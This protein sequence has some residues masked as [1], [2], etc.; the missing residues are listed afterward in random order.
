MSRS[1]ILSNGELAVALDDRAQVRDIYYPYVGLEDHVRGHY[2]HRIGVWSEGHLSWLSDP[3]WKVTVGCESEAL[4]SAVF[5]RNE[6]MKIELHSTDIV[7][8]ERSI[9]LRKIQIKNVS[10]K[11][12]DIKLYIGHQFEIYK[13]HGGDTAYFDPQTHS[14]IHYKGHR[15]FLMGGL[16]NEKPF[17]DYVT[18]LAN[19]AGHEGSHKDA[20][21]GALT[22]NPI[23]HGPADSVVGFYEE[24]APGQEHT[25]DYWIAAGQT[26]SEAQELDT[27]VRTKK[28]PAHLI[29]STR[30]Y[31]KA[32]VNAYNWNFLGLTPEHVDLFKR[33]LLYIRGHVDNGGGILASL[34]SD[35]LNYGLDTYAYVWPRDAS[36]SVLALDAVGDGNSARKFFEFCK[37]VLFKDGYLM[38]KY[39][40]DLSLGSSWHPW[41][42]NGRAELPIQEDETAI[43]VY[44]LGAHYAH[45]HDV[46]FLESM[47][48]QFIEKTAD[49]MVS[50][51]DPE[52]HLPLASYD[53]WEEKRGVST[54]SAS[55]VFG[56]L[57]VAAE[58]SRILGK[59]ENEKRYAEAAD[60]MKEGILKY[61]WDEKEGMFIKHLNKE[62]TQME[63]DKTL[64]A[65]SVY[66]IFL[67][68][69]LPHDDPR[70]KRAFEITARRLSF[71]IPAGGLAR[72]EGDNYFRNDRESAGNPWIVTTLWYAEY[73]IANAKKEQDFN[74]V[75]DIFT[76][77]T[78]HMLPSGVLPEQLNPQTGEQ[79]SVAPLTWSHSAYVTAVIKYLNKLEELGLCVAC[80]PAP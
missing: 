66:G 33:S 12:R 18:G 17:Q 46:T 54:Y 20:E 78:K 51:R 44:A 45:T 5:A 61:L 29:R 73:L 34:D 59:T 37:Q 11:K 22:K 53:L 31:W 3:D 57:Q 38:H 27:F 4:A 52:T 16:I 62:G 56:A 74:H 30:D 60:A 7:Y 71:G 35:T 6:N 28:S 32:W 79:L 24:Y 77:V 75:R 19:F 80:N 8:N 72:Y 43:V 10:D 50:Y 68:E 49:F 15:V 2:V 41:V 67:F 40:P 14:V 48:D 69:V 23:E 9:F 58:L 26:I 76:W 13:S 39:L 55:C 36:Y 64:D 63:F 25:I 65:S 47:Y 42:R 21:D 70:L 1:I